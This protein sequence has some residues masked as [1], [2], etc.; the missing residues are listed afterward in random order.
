MPPRSTNAPN[1]TTLDTVPWRIS[2]GLRL[3]RKL[4]RLSFCVSS[5]KA[6]RLSTTLLRFLSSSMIFACTVL[7]TY[8]ARSRTRRSSTSDAGRKPRRPMSTMRPPLTT[9]MTGPSTMPSASLIFSMVPHARSYCARF[10]RQQQAAFLVLLL[11]DE[12]LDL[13]AEGDDL[14]RVDVVADA[15]LASEDDAFA[16]VAD[17][18]QHLVP[19]D[20]HHRAVDEL[21]VFDVDHR[22]VDG[23][24]E[25]HAEVVGDDL[26]GG[27]V[28][29]VVERAPGGGGGRGAV[30]VSDKGDW[31]SKG[32]GTATR[33]ISGPAE[34]TT[35]LTRSGHHVARRVAST[36]NSGDSVV[37][38]ALAVRAR[39][40]AAR[41]TRPA[42]RA[43]L[44]QQPQLARRVAPGPQ[45]DLDAG[46]PASSRTSVRSWLTPGVGVERRPPSWYL[47]AK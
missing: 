32:Y 14:V 29:L 15:E 41:P 39:F 13:V 23:V 10:L 26:A 27:V 42:A 25:G 34:V 16:L 37:G 35:M 6:R 30:A 40:D 33:R 12:R 28:A 8:G 2:P 43:A 3:V 46:S 44:S 47:T 1:D 21:A 4:S 45:V 20:L 9:S 24:G 7:P 19:V 5:R 36:R 38:G 31:L 18:E 11:E 17:V 22:A